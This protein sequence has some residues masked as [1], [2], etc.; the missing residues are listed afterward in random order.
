MSV[1]YQKVRQIKVIIKLL[2]RIA[3]STILA[4]DVTVSR[5]FQRKIS[6]HKI[7]FLTIW[8]K[9]NEIYAS[10]RKIKTVVCKSTWN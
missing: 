9:G 3:T 10:L 8:S 5:L 2:I 7:E 6:S 4:L 1:I